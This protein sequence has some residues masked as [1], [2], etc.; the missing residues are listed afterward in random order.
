LIAIRGVANQ[1]KSTSIK[2]A[3]E[4]IKNAYPRAN[5]E[6]I[7]IGVDITVVVTINGVKVGIESQGDPKSRLFESLRRFVKIDCKVI[8][9]ATRSRGATV[10][11]VSKLAGKY[12]INWI[13][14]F[15]ASTSRAQGASNQSVAQQ[16]LA[17]VQAA[18]GV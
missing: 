17:A 9:C 16:I 2:L 6:E 5:F 13:N 14:K 3:Y 12:N 10:D 18:I 8:I 11:A 4:L 15:G 7:N 1:G